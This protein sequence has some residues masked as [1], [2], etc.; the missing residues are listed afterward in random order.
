MVRDA[1]ESDT[2]PEP[3]ARGVRAIVSA[4]Q[5]GNVA[6]LGTLLDTRPDLV[7]AM[8]G[9]IKK[10]TA[11]HLAVLGNHHDAIRLLIARGADV[12][13]RDFPDNA[14]PLHFAAMHGD[15][16]T[17]RLLVEAGADV[18]GR[19]DD[20]D[21]GVLGWATCFRQVRDG[22]AAYLLAHGAGLNLWSAIALDRAEDVRAMIAREPSLL[23]ARMSRNQH[24]RTPLHHAAAKNRA[25]IVRL[26]LEPGADPNATDATGATA[27]TTA[28]Q[29]NAGTELI[30]ALLAAGA[31]LDFLTAVNLGRHAE[32]EAMLRE[33]PARSDPTDATRSRCISP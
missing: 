27:L 13:P 20:Y 15:M 22:V 1:R 24:R 19:G 9:G 32:A 4:A 28:S 21:V 30:D 12:D 3:D 14:T 16:E 25:R 26:L 11:L 18:D 7:D 8:G 10:A 2:R 29:E 31:P 5:S 17:V 23:A 6:E 33:D